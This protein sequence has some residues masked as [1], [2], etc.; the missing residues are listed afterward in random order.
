MHIYPQPPTNSS[1][2]WSKSF[3]I[4][5]RTLVQSCTRRFRKVSFFLNLETTAEGILFADI[6]L[7]LRKHWFNPCLYWTLRAQGN[8]TITLRVMKPDN[9][10]SKP[11]YQT[12]ICFS[13]SV[14]DCNRPGHQGRYSWFHCC[15]RFF[16][17]CKTRY[18]ETLAVRAL[19]LAVAP[20]L[21]KL[22]FLFPVYGS[23]VLSPFL[24]QSRFALK[25]WMVTMCMYSEFVS[26]CALHS[27]LL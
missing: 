15:V 17:T 19:C 25:S 1:S 4:K 13:N 11:F 9:F 20:N 18:N 21:W 14:A 27:N 6:I 2:H 12:R 5:G 7:L 3:V 26:R 8:W 24:I 10:I 22:K 23:I 16:F